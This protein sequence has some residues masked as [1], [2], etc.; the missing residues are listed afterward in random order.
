MPF[1]TCALCK[2]TD[3]PESGATIPTNGPEVVDTFISI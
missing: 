2:P 1:V 3:W